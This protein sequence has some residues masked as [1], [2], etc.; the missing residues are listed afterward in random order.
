VHLR[1]HKG[2]LT[3]RNGQPKAESRRLF[4]P[5]NRRAGSTRHLAGEWS[6]ALTRAQMTRVPHR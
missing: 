2:P 1:L 4:N 6:G 3:L 5:G